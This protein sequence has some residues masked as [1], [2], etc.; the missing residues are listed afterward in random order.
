MI[1]SIGKTFPEFNLHF[2]LNSNKIKQI[3][4]SNIANNEVMLQAST[5]KSK[6]KLF[7]EKSSQQNYYFINDIGDFKKI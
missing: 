6:L 1:N 3:I 4:V 7:L 2:L 5:L